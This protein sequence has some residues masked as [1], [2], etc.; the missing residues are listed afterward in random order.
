[1]KLSIE[2][3]QIVHLLSSFCE[4]TKLFIIINSCNW[5]FKIRSVFEC[6]LTYIF[7]I[8]WLTC[9]WLNR[10]LKIHSASTDDI[11]FFPLGMIWQCKWL[12]VYPASIPSYMVIWQSNLYNSVIFA[13]TSW[14]VHQNSTVSISESSESLSTGLL[15]QTR[16]WP[17][18]EYFS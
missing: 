18:L 14:I 8:S 9:Y 17:W 1:M 12:T 7:S 16:T 3:R 13:A 10:I 15:E 6:F 5:L 4:R 2:S 11:N